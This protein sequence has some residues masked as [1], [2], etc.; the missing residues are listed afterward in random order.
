MAI[1]PDVVATALQDLAP[2]YSELFTL[3][4]P[5][6]ERVVKKGNIDRGTLKGPYKEFVVVTD[7]PGQVTQ[8][9]TG[10]EV[11]A[12]GRRQVDLRVRRPR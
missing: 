4:H 9:L 2:G 1:S 6:M 8:V 12:G 7:G 11:I 10:S 3:W 5:I